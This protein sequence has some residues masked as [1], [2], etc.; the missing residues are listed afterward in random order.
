MRSPLD[1][2]IR[3]LRAIQRGRSHI[4]SPTQ[5]ALEDEL[6]DEDRWHFGRLYLLVSRCL[7]SQCG[8]VLHTG[9]CA[10]EHFGPRLPVMLFL[11]SVADEPADPGEACG[12][13]EPRR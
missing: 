8:S 11:Y 2:G 9:V 4:A 1:S 12:Q 6:V 7:G 13:R 3:L 10:L 5:W